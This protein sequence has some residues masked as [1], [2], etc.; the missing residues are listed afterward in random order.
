MSEA[1]YYDDLLGRG[2]GD[3]DLYDPP[4]KYASFGGTTHGLSR[5][6]PSEYATWKSIR[7]RCTNPNNKDYPHYGGKGVSICE[8]WSDFANFFSDMG[9]RPSDKHS[10]D[11]IDNDGNYEPNNCRWASQLVQQ[12]NK[13]RNGPAV[14]D[15]E[16]A[17]KIRELYARGWK[18]VA[19]ADLF[20]VHKQTIND[21]VH[22]K[23]YKE[24]AVL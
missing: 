4:S 5:K 17:K 23:Y 2:A 22:Q 24:K 18:Q 6:H 19:L 7:Q 15:H 16:T 9:E 20:M 12:N 3:G 13:S 14:L 10:I 8:R 11:R 1:E 21:I